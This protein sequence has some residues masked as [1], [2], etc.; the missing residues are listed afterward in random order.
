V[1]PLKW[2]VTVLFDGV[3]SNLKQHE[4]ARRDHRQSLESDAND[5]LYIAM[6][7]KICDGMKVPFLV[8]AYEADSQCFFVSLKGEPLSLI[9]MG[10][11]D[12]VAYGNKRVIIIK[13][14]KE[15]T[16]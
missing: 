3:E 4:R 9:V 6:A 16:F 11:S 8:A 14:W 1:T 10:D 12:L 15:E 5:P 7:A 2:N 13:S